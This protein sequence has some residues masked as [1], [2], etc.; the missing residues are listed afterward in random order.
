[1]FFHDLHSA[2]FSMIPIRVRMECRR[3]QKET[4][5]YEEKV[6]KTEEKRWY[7]GMAEK[8]VEVKRVG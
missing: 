7:L 1:M 6:T 8:E 5:L 4:Y 2:A 3:V